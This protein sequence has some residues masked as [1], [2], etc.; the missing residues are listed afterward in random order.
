MKSRSFVALL[1]LLTAAACQTVPITGRSQ[2]NIMSDQQ[3][4]SIADRNFS[5]FMTLVNSKNAVL[6]PSE[7]P[8]AAAATAVVN[9]VCDRIIDAA[10]LRNQ[11][12]W[13]TVIV[14]SREAN[15][16]VMPNGKIV[17]FTGLLPIAKTEG[18][19]AAV[20]GHEVG[21]VVAHHQAER[22]SQALLAQA[23]ATTADIALAASSNSKYRPIVGAALGLGAQYGLLLPFSRKHESEADHIGLFYMAKAG[24]DP[25]EAI[26]L[27]E[28]MEAANGSGPW[29]YLSTHPSAATRRQQ[30]REWLPEANLYY[31]DRARPFPSNLTEVTK[32]TTAH[33][34]RMALAPIAAR[35]TYQP[36]YWYRTKSSNR[37]ASVAS[38][39]VDPEDCPVGKCL[40][41][42]SETGDKTFYTDDFAA[43]M[44]TKS[45]G[46]YIRFSPPLKSTIWPMHVGDTWSQVVTLENE[47]G[48][49]QILRLKGDVVTYESVTVP[50]GTFM[51]FKI[52]LS[53]DGRRF[54]EGWY[55]PEARF[56]VRSVLYDVRGGQVVNELVDFQKSDE[57]VGGLAIQRDLQKK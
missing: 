4:A 14:K 45:D 1:L 16:F 15:A 13:Q 54:R 48:Q 42:Q 44:A 41:M 56:M 3:V 46:S 32:A 9:R 49:K 22:V 7:S 29:E 35:P 11:Y 31:A 2:L 38:H 25:S 36:G 18:A 50:A 37:P 23:A 5:A 8:Q 53:A 52:I 28:R 47:K 34:E 43:V 40:V 19:L 10:G 33:A 24:Y 30:I 51:A 20:L 26:G 55:A 21:H 27:W 12:R 6:G 57:P 17:V 39:L